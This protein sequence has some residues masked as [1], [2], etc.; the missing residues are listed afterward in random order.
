MESADIEFRR[1]LVLEHVGDHGVLRIR[2]FGEEAFLPGSLIGDDFRHR[3]AGERAHHDIG[4][5][6]L[7]APRTVAYH[8][9]ALAIVAELDR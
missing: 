5:K 9:A 3:I 7:P 1:R 6:F 4:R 8:A 2:H